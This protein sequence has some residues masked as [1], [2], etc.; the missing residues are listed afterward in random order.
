VELPCGRVCEEVGESASQRPWLPETKAQFRQRVF[1]LFSEEFVQ[2][3][4]IAFKDNSAPMITKSSILL[5]ASDALLKL[6]AAVWANDTDL[7][8]SG[9]VAEVVEIQGGVVSG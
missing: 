3:V 6:V 7:A 1:R 4:N 9:A 5:Q 2:L 8:F